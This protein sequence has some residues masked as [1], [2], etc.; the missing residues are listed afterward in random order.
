[1]SLLYSEVIIPVKPSR[2][3]KEDLS[4]RRKGAKSSTYGFRIGTLGNKYNYCIL[5]NVSPSILSEFPIIVPLFLPPDVEVNVTVSPE[6]V[7]LPVSLS[8]R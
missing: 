4:Q 5:V 6:T 1:M 8:R 3:E 2:T 7:K